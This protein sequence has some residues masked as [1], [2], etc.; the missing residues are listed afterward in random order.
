MLQSF[1]FLIFVIDVEERIK[2]KIIQ[3]EEFWMEKQIAASCRSEQALIRANPDL[4]DIWLNNVLS[5]ASRHNIH[6][7]VIDVYLRQGELVVSNTGGGIPI[8]PERIYTRFFKQQQHSMNN[9]LG[10]AIIKQICEQAQIMVSYRFI[11]HRHTFS[12]YWTS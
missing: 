10:L 1:F 6:H 7:G 4:L 12:F 11:D 5:N 9:G 8:D 2:D 3:L